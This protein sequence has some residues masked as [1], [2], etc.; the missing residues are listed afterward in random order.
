MSQAFPLILLLAAMPAVAADFFVAPGGLDSNPGTEAQPWKTIQRAANAGAVGPGDTVFIREGVY[1]ERVT[2]SVSG[3]AAGGVV[4]YRNYPGETVVLDA[5]GVTPPA[6]ETGLFLIVGKSHVRI[7]GLELRNYKSLSGTTNQNH[8]PCGVHIR[9]AS[10]HIEV[11]N[12]RIHDVWNHF[13]DG[14]AFGIAVYGDSPTPMTDIVIDGNEI[15]QCRTGNSETLSINGNVTQWQ[16]TNNLVHDNTN[17]GIDAIGYEETCCGGTSDPVLDRARNGIIR[18]NRVWNCSSA[19]IP[20]TGVPS[21]PAYGGAP[22]AGGIYVDGAHGILIERNVSYQN[23]IGI[24]LASEHSGKATESVTVRGNVVWRNR[25]GGLFMGGA[26]AANGAAQNNTV[27]NNTFWENDVNQDGNGEIQFNHRVFNN[28]LRN[29]LVVANSQSLLLTNPVAATVGGVAM[30]TGNVIDYN[31]WQAPA[32]SGAAGW[33]WKNVARTGFA[34]WKTAIGGDVNSS[35][36][37][38][39]FV[40]PAVAGTAPPAAPD[41]HL[42][43]DSPCIDAGD[44]AFGVG[45][46]E[47]DADGEARITGGRVDIGADELAPRDGWRNQ[48]FGAPANGASTQL[49]ADPDGDGLPNLMEYALGAEPLIAGLAPLPVR[50]TVLVGADRYLTLTISRPVEASDITYTIQATSSP[51]QWTDGCTYGPAGDVGVTPATTQVSR[52]VN[53]PLETIVVR[54][55][56][57]LGIEPHRALR[58]RIQAP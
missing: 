7:Q 6:T 36:G 26:G 15:Y 24:E 21:N 30:N 20:A 1:S 14:N 48:K 33:Q 5:T 25:I 40:N 42:R 18:G 53:G 29:N 2:V 50:G 16:V 9:G 38:P 55:N 12:C 54:D 45:A 49:G 19:G 46:G 47:K 52:T 31:R 44:P 8:V 39:Q 34:A 35:F 43:L 41:L 51:A 17:I 58:L 57:P 56:T 27:T 3:S 13:A 23:D 32:G 28:S 10:D 4:T 11:R 37:D 22:G